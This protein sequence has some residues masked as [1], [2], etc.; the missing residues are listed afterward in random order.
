MAK[1]VRL[2]AASNWGGLLPQYGLSEVRFFSVPVGAREPSPDSGASD[3]AP[4]VTL[5]WRAGREAGTHD[6]YLSTDEQ[7]VIDGAAPVVSVTDA[8]YSAVLD[9]GSTYYWRIDEVNDAETPTMW[10]SDVWDFSTPEYLVVDGF[11][12]YNDYPPD[13]I[14]TTWLD[15]YEN[16]ANGSQVGYLIPPTIETGTVHGGEQSMPLLYSNIGGATYS[17]A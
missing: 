2:T 13:E 12:D 8:S 7:A 5:A 6:V 9:L 16:P 17:E 3:V 1:Y 11:E 15:G 4:A 14:Y 10:Q